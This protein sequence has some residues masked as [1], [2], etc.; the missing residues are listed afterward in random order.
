MIC[1]NFYVEASADD[2]QATNYRFN[3][4]EYDKNVHSGSGRITL[5]NGTSVSGHLDVLQ[6]NYDHAVKS[7]MASNLILTQGK[8]YVLWAN[9]PSQ[10]TSH[11]SKKPSVK[12]FFDFSRKA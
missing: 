9:Y 8:V 3:L 2:A 7:N 4:M 5:S 12:W 6:A 1:K 10:L 11:P